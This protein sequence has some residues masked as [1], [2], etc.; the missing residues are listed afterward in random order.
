MANRKKSNAIYI[1]I[2]ICLMIVGLAL[3]IAGTIKFLDGLWFLSIIAIPFP[4]AGLVF[5][6]IPLIKKSGDKLKTKNMELLKEI[7][8]ELQY[9]GSLCS[10][11]GTINENNSR[12]CKNCGK[13]LFRICPLCNSRLSD[14]D[15]FCNQCGN[16]IL[17][18]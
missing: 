2:G 4:V 9:S 10:F 3:F 6:L 18:L 8:N 12:F 11:C 17:P 14:D 5:I 7:R 13:P 16:E 1:L 15:K